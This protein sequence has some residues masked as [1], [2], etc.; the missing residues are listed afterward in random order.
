MLR[1]SQEIDMI[2]TWQIALLHINEVGHFSFTYNEEQKIFIDGNLIN[3]EWVIN[4]RVDALPYF[5]WGCNNYHT[6]ISGRYTEVIRYYLYLVYNQL[7]EY[8]VPSRDK[9]LEFIKC[10]MI[11]NT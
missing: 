9:L 11:W 4:I 1:T 3:D 8:E 2:P 5:I 7:S 10:K 6:K